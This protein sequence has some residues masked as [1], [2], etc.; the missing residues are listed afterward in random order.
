VRELNPYRVLLKRLLAIPEKN[1]YLIS[2]KRRGYMSGTRRACGCFFGTLA[3]P[4]VRNPR[5]ALTYASETRYSAKRFTIWINELL[6]EA[7]IGIVPELETL[8]DTYLSHENDPDSCARRFV[9]MVS[10]LDEKARTWDTQ[11][12]GET[13]EG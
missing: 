6:G 12:K 4:R 9:Y 7:A 3:P 10:V 2:H 11:M 1:H 13:D 8:N 5:S